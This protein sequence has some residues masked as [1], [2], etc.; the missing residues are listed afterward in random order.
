M[1]LYYTTEI[2]GNHAVLNKS[3]SGHLIKVM[4]MKKGDLVHLTDG[5]GNLYEGLIEI[6]DP[7]KTMVQLRDVKKDFGKRDFYMHMAVA[8]T[9]NIS[10]FE[11]F[12]EKATEMGVDEIT[13]LI[14]MHS[15]RK[16]VKRDRSER[17]LIAAMKQSVK[18]FLPVI[19]EVVGFEAL[20]KHDFRGQKFIAYIDEK[21]KGRLKDKYQKGE[22]A[23]I[24]IGPEGDFSSKEID[25]AIAHGF[26]PISLGKSRLRTETAA[27]VACHTVN[28]MNG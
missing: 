10:R 9:K 25:M 27:F 1:Q 26:V 23:L 3:D 24:L 11:W 18:A 13:P 14:C 22:D 17:V 19:N 21:V 4:R 15:E 7:K 8:P 6:D 2:S 16:V 28:L 5:L 12:L 20:L